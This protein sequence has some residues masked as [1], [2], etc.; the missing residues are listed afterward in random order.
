MSSRLIVIISLSKIKDKLFMDKILTII[1]PTYN[2]EKYLRH[3]LDSL[4][5]PNMDKVEVLVIN[6]GSKDSSSVIGHEYQ[7][8]YPQTFRVID[9]ENGNYGSCVNRGLKEATG[10]YVKVL[11]A[12][13]SF[14]TGNF[15]EYV[16][17]L[18]KFDVDLVLNDFVYITQDNFVCAKYTGHLL[19]TNEIFPFKELGANCN[20]MM[21]AV[22]YKTDNIRNIPGGY[23]Q[24]E[25]ISYT[26]Q[27]WIF[28]PM[29][30]VSSI[31]YF[32][33]ILY[34]YLIGRIGQTMDNSQM[35]KN[36]W[37]EAKGEKIMIKSYKKLAASTLN[38]DYLYVRLKN[39][40]N[41]IYRTCLIN[42]KSGSFN[43]KEFDSWLKEVA[44]ELYNYCGTI[45]VNSTKLGKSWPI[46]K[47]WRENKLYKNI[48]FRLWN[49]LHNKKLYR[50][51]T[52]TH[53]V[54][55]ENNHQ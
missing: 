11:D 29:A 19:P 3:C 18:E 32:D 36:I 13:D 48:L 12:D 41:V 37:M 51:S 35:I 49:Y 7:D 55:F 46:V 50:N 9:K 34:K 24:T 33:K 22:A 53:I 38:K 5:V 14:D 6:D 54:Y 17:Y 25:G 1:I 27:E 47:L 43:L 15:K 30:T 8:K 20:M 23:H 28:L 4:I 16:D 52:T 26:D 42:R 10:K 45:C 44:P 40:L 21:H 31:V 2:M 39:R